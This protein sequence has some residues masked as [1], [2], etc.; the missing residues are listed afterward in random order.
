MISELLERLSSET[1]KWFRK[2]RA[3]ALAIS[4]M[5]TAVK[6]AIPTIDGLV[7]PDRLS[8]ILNYCIV[9]GIAASAVSTTACTNS[10]V[11]KPKINA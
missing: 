3:F 11:K 1:P 6:L 8:D 5:A 4:G 7:I 10:P 2:I 9:A